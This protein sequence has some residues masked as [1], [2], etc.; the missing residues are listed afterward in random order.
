MKATLLLLA[1]FDATDETDAQRQLDN[2]REAVEPSTNYGIVLYRAV[3]EHIS[4]LTSELIK[5]GYVE[6]P[7]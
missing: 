1:E 2:F 7:S 3:Q 6:Q 5:N 4:Y